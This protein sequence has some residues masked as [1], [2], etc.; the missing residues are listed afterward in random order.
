MGIDNEEGP[1]KGL[2]WATT[3][4]LLTR[5]RP[6]SSYATPKL[7]LSSAHSI[8]INI[9]LIITTRILFVLL[10]FAVFLFLSRSVFAY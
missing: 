3:R 8:N 9:I 7:E 4:H 1:W 2:G 6:Y 10:F 5:T